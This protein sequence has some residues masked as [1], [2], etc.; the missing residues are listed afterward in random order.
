MSS[1]TS[2]PQSASILQPLAE[3][4]Q[5]DDDP[6]I[7]LDVTKD[8]AQAIVD[9]HG[10]DDQRDLDWAHVK[11][12]SM[13]MESGEWVGSSLLSFSVNGD[14]ILRL[15]DGHHR[16][17]AVIDYMMSTQADTIMPIRFSAQALTRHSAG[18]AYAQL[19]SAQKVRDGAVIGK[20]LKLP[21]PR[22]VL[23]A[24]LSIAKQALIYSDYDR[25]MVLHADN[26]VI[27]APIR[28]AEQVAYVN[29]RRAEYGFLAEIIRA[30]GRSTGLA[31]FLTGAKMA[32]VVIETLAAN[33][34]DSM[35][36]WIGVAN[37]KESTA[38]Q[39]AREE[40]FNH[41][42]QD[43]A[44]PGWRPFMFAL[45]WLHRHE[46]D[47]DKLTRALTRTKEGI[48]IG[49]YDSRDVMIPFCQKSQK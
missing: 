34:T 13:L 39:F 10:F 45:C 36:Y 41:L 22:E 40:F 11:H 24:A 3:M 37:G 25:N 35:P 12:L 23:K 44:R 8:A 29:R 17:R 32:P 48:Q 30:T 38:G 43:R 14:G 9:Y 2:A 1:T 47:T 28:Y 7:T 33:K 5:T 26:K 16:L 31:R 42:T 46:S 6:V 4:A 15:V 21:V 18:E 49:T 20:A 27:K 19:D